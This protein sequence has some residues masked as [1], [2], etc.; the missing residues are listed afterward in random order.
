M[1]EIL[2][3]EDNDTMREGILEILSRSGH[4][5]QS[6]KN[7]ATGIDLYKKIRPDFVMTDLKMEGLDGFAVLK[8]IQLFDPHAIVVVITAFGTIEIAVEAMKSGAFDFITKPFPPDLLRAKVD[9]ALSYARL[10]AENKFLRKETAKSKADFFLGHS[11]SIQEIKKQIRLAAPSDSTIL[12]LGQS[13]TGKDLVARAIHEQSQRNQGPWIKTD[14]SVLAENLLESELFGHEKGA[15]TGAEHRKQG[16]FELADKGTIFLDEIGELPSHVQTKLLRVLQERTFERVG[17]TRPI[18]VD[19][20]IIA[21]TNRNLEN[22]VK[23]GRF[24]EDLFYRLNI[25]P[26]HVPPLKDRKEDIEVLVQH[27]VSKYTQKTGKS[28]KL[29]ENVI[30]I[31][32]KYQWPGNV[33]ELENTIERLCVMSTTEKID[34]TDLPAV[35]KKSHD[36]NYIDTPPIESLKLTE[37]LEK[38]ERELISRAFEKAGGVKLKTARLLGIKPSALYYKLEKYGIHKPQD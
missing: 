30:P 26:I 28:I 35:F 24:R 3:I 25:I 18:Q 23:E 38:I 10:K 22:E 5:V 6:A 13:G 21:A 4:D 16:R 2:I 33:R 11:S 8:E 14:C 27:F 29:S 9:Q 36:L 31:L 15:F 37:A 7:G 1:A 34:E 12:I 19:V 17:G 32:L 20:R